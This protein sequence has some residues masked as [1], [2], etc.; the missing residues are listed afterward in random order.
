MPE[1][2]IIS[3]TNTVVDRVMNG[4]INDIISGKIK[5]GDKLSTET[6]LSQQYSAGR[7]S[8]RE[9]IKMLQAFGV[10]YIKRADGT[11][12]SQKYEQKMLD[13][14]LYSLILINN[15]KDDFVDLRAMIDIGVLNVIISR[16]DFS[17]FLPELYLTFGNLTA[18]LHSEHPDLEKVIELDNRFHA[19]IA[20]AA[21]NQMIN[22]IVSYITR[23]TLPSRLDTTKSIIESGHI[24]EFC[25]L[26]RDILNVIEERRV[27]DITKVVYD[28]YVYWK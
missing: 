19:E 20:S 17:K 6:E 12:V 5:P 28:H 9:A 18:E 15:S 2:D 1:T 25:A 7:N 22:T 21:N 24:D 3:H 27:N 8:V 16:K 13:P 4:I 23:L 10:V 26:H 14:M 11:Y